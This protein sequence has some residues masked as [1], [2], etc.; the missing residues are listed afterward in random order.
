MVKEEELGFFFIL[1]KYTGG[2]EMIVKFSFTIDFCTKA[3]LRLIAI[4]IKSLI[5]K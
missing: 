1:S 3:I 2:Y 5:S 4:V